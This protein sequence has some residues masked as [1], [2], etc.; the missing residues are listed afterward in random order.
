[1]RDA[2]LDERRTPASLQ[3]V[4]GHSVGQEIVIGLG[5]P[6]KVGRAAKLGPDFGRDS[7]MS[8]RH[9]AIVY[10]DNQCLIRDLGS[11]NGTFVNGTM[12]VETVLRDG[13]RIEA[14]TSTFVV[15]L[16]SDGAVRPT[17]AK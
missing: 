3:I 1:M 12:I 11:R 15:R 5:E 16:Q 14:G 17:R 13:D 4:S 2:V 6:V 10:R 7:H 8:A 9:F